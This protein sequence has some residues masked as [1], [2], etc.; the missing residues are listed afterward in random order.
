MDNW[1][2]EEFGERTPEPR[3]TPNKVYLRFGRWS[4]RSK[5]HA[6]GDLER[7]VSVYPA[8]LIDGRTVELDTDI[9]I[10]WHLVKDRLVFP[11]MGKFICYGSDGEP[12]IRKLRMLPY[13][14]SLNGLKMR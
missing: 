13:A 7:G 14:V 11:V 3:K 9:D 5:N 10:P 8:R 12:V 6:T 4:T 2:T 1:F